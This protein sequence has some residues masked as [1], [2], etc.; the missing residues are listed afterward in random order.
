MKSSGSSSYLL[1]SF[2]VDFIMLFTF[3]W[4]CP[5]FVHLTRCCPHSCLFS[6]STTFPLEIFLSITALFGWFSCIIAIPNLLPEK[7]ATCL[8]SEMFHSTVKTTHPQIH[9]LLTILFFPFVAETLCMWGLAAC[10]SKA[11]KQARLVERKV[12]LILDA[13]NWEWERVADICPKANCP[14]PW[15]VGGGNFYRQSRRC[16]CRN[17]IVISDS[18]LLMGHQWSYKH[19]LDFFRYN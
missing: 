9:H 10:F 5:V 15:Q 1:Y 16:T 17:S 2:F 11:N 8:S 19:H 7:C 4:F 18:P 12:C 6:H 13:G 3:L 14:P